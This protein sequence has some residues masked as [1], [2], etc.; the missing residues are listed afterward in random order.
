MM[1]RPEHD[2]AVTVVTDTATRSEH[3]P[4]RT[5]D[6][7][8]RVFVSSSLQELAK[9]RRAVRGAIESLRLTPVMFE[10]GAR[11]HPPRALYRAYLEQSDVFIGLYWERY[12][13]VAPGEK[14]SGLEDEYGLSGDRPKLIYIKT[15]SS[16]REPRLAQLID[17]IQRDDRVSYRSFSDADDLRSVVADDLAVLLTERYS[18]SVPSVAFRS[19]APAPLPRPPTRLVGRD[20]EVVRVLDLLAEPE[21]RLVTIFGSGGI[22]KSRLA[23]AVAERAK[24]RYTDD[25][26]YVDLAAVTE[27]SLLL[28]TIAVAVGVQEGS[29][30]SLRVHLRDRLA[31]A[32]MLMVLDNM[33]Q[34]IDA[35]SEVSDLLAGT[36]A[37]QMLVTSRRILDVRGERVFELEP[38][39]LPG[40]NG[41]IT[42]AV[43]LFVERARGFR[44]DYQPS[45]DDLVAIAELTRRLDGL[46]LAI[47]LA[48]ARLRLLSP[49]AVLERMGHARLDFLRTGPSDIPPRQRTLRDTIAWSHSLLPSGSR[50]LFARLAVFV[51]SADLVAIEDVTNP[52][53]KLDTLDLLADLV[54]QSLVRATSEAGEPRFGMLETIREFAVE[55]LEASG[56]AAAYRARHA[57]HYLA[58][59]ERGNAALGSAHQVQWLAR[60]GRENDNFRAV[61]RRALRRDDAAAAVRMGRALSSYWS[62]HSSY[63]E[64]RGWMDRISALP[65]AGAY[66]RAMAWTIGAIQAF[67]QGNFDQLETGLDEAAGLAV[68]PLDRRIVALAQ[69]L[70]SLASG[71]RPAD[72]RWHD[73]LTDASRKLEAEGEPLAIGFGLVA[74]AVL[75]RVHGR[76]DEAKR[77][78]QAGY[79]LSTRIGES[80]VRMFASAQLA[81]ATLDLGD[82][83]NVPRHA[84][85]ALLAAQRLGNV[86]AESYAL[87]LWAAAELRDGRIERAGRLFALAERGYKQVGSGPWP[88]DAELHRQVKTDLQAA[89]GYLYEQMVAE[90]RDV[91]YDEAITEIAES[92]RSAH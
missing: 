73:T 77:L 60:L 48:S 19:R 25:V 34:L 24:D 15:P 14:I 39:A 38:L 43:E 18:A 27:P 76:P 31:G 42:A 23:L 57:A 89:L 64:G 29:G 75:S 70:Q 72:E 47:E 46:P 33:E 44:P 26:A 52:N 8:L 7:R 28:S 2:D 3:V 6:Q 13:W 92:E 90:A 22:G 45:D 63:S 5:P 65:S 82:A 36:D 9:E 66:E 80:Y 69:L 74:R 87:A 79:D 35:V 30:G 91:D 83:A 11:P 81:R 71:M 85:E 17:R 58:L 88:T 54:E 4:I 10:Q 37:L 53:G 78:A 49:H 56:E 50:T 61:L 32:Q 41:G 55:R 86:I 12:G 16:S 20:D 21:T 1:A 84:V 59:A 68:E 62:M 51:G 67:L 40:A